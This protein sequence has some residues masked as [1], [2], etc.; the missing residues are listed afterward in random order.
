M[1]QGENQGVSIILA[2]RTAIYNLLHAIFGGD[3][4]ERVLEAL[5]D[6]SLMQLISVFCDDGD[7]LQLS[8]QHL[9][10]HTRALKTSDPDILD[11]LSSVYCRLFVGPGKVEAEPWE[12]VYNEGEAMLFQK[13]TLDVRK[14]YVAQGFIPKSYPHVADDHIALE[15]DFMRQLAKRM[16]ETLASDSGEYEVLRQASAKFLSS[17]MLNWVPLFYAK[18]ESAREQLIYREAAAL[19]NE[20][21]KIDLEVL[22]ELAK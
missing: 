9:E 4:Q 19:L 1:G 20:F 16:E 21:L 10:E 7:S 18:V 3:P 14:A 17:H 13:S 6:G 12:S 15:L 5:S 22:D 8:A 11:K 2:A